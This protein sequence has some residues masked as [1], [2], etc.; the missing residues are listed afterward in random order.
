M[1]ARACWLSRA[2]DGALAGERIPCCSREFVAALRQALTSA[3]DWV[4]EFAVSAKTFVNAGAAFAA[5]WV[6]ES[7]AS[8]LTDSIRVSVR[9]GS[10][11]FR[12][13]SALAAARLTIP[14]EVCFAFLHVA[15]AFALLVVPVVRVVMAGLCSAFKVAD[16][17]VESVHNAIQGVRSAELAEA[18]AQGL[19]VVVA[20]VTLIGV[21]NESATLHVPALTGGSGC[22]W[23]VAAAL[24]R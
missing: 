21:V 17:R 7:A 1:F 2:L 16:V 19:V 4:V 13:A 23:G 20:F 18:L 15:S 3:F 11:V 10:R 9:V 5:D 8:A 6:P 24:T 22:G 12:Y 14:F